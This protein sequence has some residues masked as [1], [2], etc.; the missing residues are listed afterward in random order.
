MGVNAG[1]QGLPHGT[2]DKR[3]GACIGM[4]RAVVDGDI[5][6]GAWQIGA[7]ALRPFN[8][9]DS[10]D[11]GFLDPEFQRVLGRVQSLE[12]KMHE[13]P[14]LSRLIGL[15]KGE[16]RAGDIVFLRAEM[17][18]DRACENRLA[19]TKRAI[20]RHH[21]TGL[22]PAR[23]EMTQPLGRGRVTKSQIKTRHVA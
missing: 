15:H 21:I 4:V 23:N 6:R 10:V 20:E 16:G 17:P 13:R 22:Q 3:D 9:T 14:A 8:Q 2:T 12:I 1:Q 19:G 5:Q 18:D 7:K 11:K